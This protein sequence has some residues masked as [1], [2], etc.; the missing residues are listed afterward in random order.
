MSAN[1]IKP[2]GAH[3]DGVRAP[4]SLNRAALLALVL[5][6]ILTPSTQ[7]GASAAA[8][9]AARPHPGDARS[10][11][12]PIAVFGRD[13]RVSVPQSLRRVASKIG[14]IH[15]PRTRSVCTAFCL[16][17][18]TVATAAH[19]LYR[20]V[21]DPPLRLSDLT[22]RLIGTH[23]RSHIAG[24]DR[25]A[26]ES[27]VLAG[28]SGLSVH[29]PINAADDWALLRLAR[30][31]CQRGWFKLARHPVADVM[32]LS[33]KDQV[34]N[35]AYHLDLPKWKPM[36]DRRCRVRRSFKDADWPTI[37]HDFTAPDQLLLHTCD[38][39][40]A[41][42]GSPLLIDGPDGPEVVGIN[43][44]TYVQSKVIMLNGEVVHRLKT[45]DVANTG[46]NALAFA[47][48]LASFRNADLLASKADIRRLQERLAARG[49]YS[50]ARNGRFGP[51]LKAAI[52]AFERASA[53]PVTGLA[54]RP[55][56]QALIGESQVVTGKIPTQ[57]REG[58]AAPRRLR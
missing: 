34:Y 48:A 31:L 42:S 16:G 39:G 22:V 49:L 30:P 32:R 45:N 27:N 50:G 12:Q 28:S 51:K 37:R 41:S 40:P 58:A 53:M 44:G 24:T 14:A 38:T 11:I 6:I 9:P 15:D 13:D 26:P 21:D 4:F 3:A 56:L 54:T 18:D 57:T 25:G 1:Q 19:C 10:L 23:A 2:M 36:L 55:L 52:E 46:V 29:P 5:A 33:A 8:L 43:V 20:T 7:N 17:P 35:I 47:D